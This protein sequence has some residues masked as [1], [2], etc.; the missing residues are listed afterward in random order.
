MKAKVLFV[1]IVIVFTSFF[2]FPFYFTFLPGINTKMILAA[3]GLGILLVRLGANGHGTISKDFLWVSICALGVSAASFLSMTLNNTSDG[4]Y[5]S[6]VVTLW[7]WVGAAYCVT[8]MIKALHGK[9]NAEIICF[10]MITV[11]VLQCL[12]AIA[13]D[14]VPAIKGFVDSFLAG[15]GFMGKA[16]KGRLYGIGCALDVAGGRFA[17]LLVMIAF[18]LPRMFGKENGNR[19][20][21]MLLTAFGIISVLGNM[22]GRTTSV[23]MVIGVAYILLAMFSKRII[24]D[25][26]DRR[27]YTRLILTAMCVTIF[28]SMVMYN[29]SDYWYKYFRFGFEGFFS[30]AEKGSWNVQSNN[31]LKEGLIFPDNLRCWII[32]DG[33][34]GS[35]SEDPFYIGELWYG[36]YKGTDAGYSRFLFYFG[37]TGMIAFIIFLAKVSQVCG[38]YSPDFRLMFWTIFLLNLIIW[39]KVSTDIFLVFA[40]FLCLGSHPAWQEADAEM[41]EGC[42]HYKL[43]E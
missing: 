7:V 3:L 41:L 2:L 5:L 33:W 4:A 23:G 9:I 6:Y 11:G 1:P 27:K 25:S 8:Q 17:V 36:F 35:M 18:L 42:V 32:G 22:I 16:V 15:E 20:I 43:N 12:L 38:K 10:Y 37:L 21:V 30:L 34:M 28:I 19:N 24:T 13:I 26:E 31:M 14:S 40:P 29:A 39:C